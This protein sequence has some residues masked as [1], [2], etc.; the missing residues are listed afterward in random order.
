MQLLMHTFTQLL[1][2]NVTFCVHNHSAPHVLQVFK[3][4]TANP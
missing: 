4:G 1:Q 2:G 3:Q